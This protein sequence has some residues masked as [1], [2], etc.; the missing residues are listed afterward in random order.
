MWWQTIGH[1]Q[2][3]VGNEMWTL[4]IVNLSLSSYSPVPVIF[5]ALIWPM[6]EHANGFATK[7]KR[8]R[9][10]GRMWWKALFMRKIEK[11]KTLLMLAMSVAHDDTLI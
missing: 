8:E 4:F 3:T 1:R 7:K 9:A 5:P 2:R 11:K 10:W 6:Y